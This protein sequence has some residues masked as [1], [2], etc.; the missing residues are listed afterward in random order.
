MEGS[1]VGAAS[2][3]WLCPEGNGET[4]GF[5]L[6]DPSDFQTALQ[7]PLPLREPIGLEEA[8]RGM[9]VPGQMEA[10]AA[11]PQGPCGPGDLT[12]PPGFPSA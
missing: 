11:L 7:K 5:T 10:G 3:G 2:S 4:E 1:K 8:G 6:C 12:Q 9:G